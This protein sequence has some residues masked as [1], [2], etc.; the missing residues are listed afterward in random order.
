MSNTKSKAILNPISRYLTSLEESILSN[1]VFEV[2]LL[3]S[4][5][6]STL[7]WTA[8]LTLITLLLFNPYTLGASSV[9]GA[10]AAVSGYICY[11]V[12]G[13]GKKQSGYP[14]FEVTH[15]IGLLF[16]FPFMLAI[17]WI[18]GMAGYYGV[19]FLGSALFGQ[20]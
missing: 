16:A 20:Q 6:S 1:I 17:A 5:T 12:Y 4:M 13:M 7:R 2:K 11:T 14:H 18:C 10:M 9:V 8:A 15:M 19:E 3:R